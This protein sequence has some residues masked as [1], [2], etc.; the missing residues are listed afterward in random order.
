MY[1]CRTTRCQG[2][3]REDECLDRGHETLSTSMG[4]RE[5]DSERSAR[6]SILVVRRVSPSP[7]ESGKET[8]SK[9][10]APPV[11]PRLPHALIRH[12]KEWRGGRQA[13]WCGPIRLA[14]SPPSRKCQVGSLN[15]QWRP[16]TLQSRPSSM[17][18]WPS[19]RRP[20]ATMQS[21]ATP[22]PSFPLTTRSS[23]N[24]A[25]TARG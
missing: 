4:G 20:F 8:P 23:P 1:L 5:R 21:M 2:T 14:S 3:N 24:F 15:R 10:K 7:L 6:L 17:S 16:A 12:I 11:S 9:V 19:S 18:G 25:R 22:R 13:E